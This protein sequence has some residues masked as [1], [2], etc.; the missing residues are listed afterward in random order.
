MGLFSETCCAVDPGPGAQFYPHPPDLPRYSPE[1]ESN[2]AARQSAASAAGRV[3]ISEKKQRAWKVWK[4]CVAG[5]YI[6]TVYIVY[7]YIYIYYTMYIYICV[8]ITL[9]TLMV[10]YYNDNINNKMCVYV[11]FYIDMQF[12]SLFSYMH[13]YAFTC[14]YR[15]RSNMG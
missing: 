1:L 7:I 9:I 15:I 10:T 12:I 14:S 8:C 3:E 13:A 11:Y 5:I 2:T 4:I 6:Y